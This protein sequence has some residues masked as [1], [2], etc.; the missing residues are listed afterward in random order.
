MGAVDGGDAA[1]VKLLLEKNADPSKGT[2]SGYS[3]ERTTPLKAATLKG[4][5]DVVGLLKQHGAVALSAAEI[6]ELLC[7]AIKENKLDV[8]R[9]LLTEDGADPSV[10]GPDAHPPLCLAAGPGNAAM[11]ELLLDKNADVNQANNN[12]ATPLHLA[13]DGGNAVIVK[14]LLEKNADVNTA[15]RNGSTPL[16]RA[17]DHNHPAII[18]LLKKHGG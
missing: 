18:T 3:W 14:L 15:D 16:S 6:Q 8:V 4:H 2:T 7:A 5:A 9:T 17:T 13:A 11:V 1:M 12:G 10:P